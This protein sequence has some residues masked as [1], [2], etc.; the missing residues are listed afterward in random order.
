MNATDHV[1]APVSPSK[2]KRDS[3]IKKIF[4]VTGMSCAVCAASVESILATVP[5]VY[6][7]SVNFAGSFVVVEYEKDT[8]EAALQNALHSIG[9]GLIIDVE[10]PSEA[11]EQQQQSHYR[12]AKERT[13][14]SAVLTFPVVVLSMLFMDWGPGKWI[15]LALSIPVLFWFGRHFFINAFRQA[16]HRKAN[17]DTLVALSTGIAF[18]FSLFNTL[19]PE[20]WHSRGIHPHVYYE[21]ATVII[22]FISLGKLLEEKAKSNTSSSIKKLMGLQP[23]TLIAIIDGE[24]VEMPIASVKPGHLIM[25]R[26]GEKVICSNSLSPE[27]DPLPKKV[28]V[29]KND[30][31]VEEE[32]MFPSP[33]KVTLL[34]EEGWAEFKLILPSCRNSA[35][36]TVLLKLLVYL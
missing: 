6:S 34:K 29:L 5:G 19:F 12:E 32:P 28:T 16:K 36:F 8:T 24:E 22:T 25:V 4:P 10:D 35:S 20:F 7:V 11:Q 26:P 18:L 13:I 30:G 9:Y 33:Q 17:M 31:C 27:I 3:I 2:K 1:L 14:W 21:A 23:K 15:S